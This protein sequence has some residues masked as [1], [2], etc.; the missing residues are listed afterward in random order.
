VLAD[1]F[2]GDDKVILFKTAVG[3]AEGTS[4]INVAESDDSSSLLNIGELQVSLF[5]N[6]G[7]KS[8]ET[9][10]VS[11]LDNL[12]TSEFSGNSLMKIDVQGYELEV[13]KGSGALLSRVNWVYVECSFLELYEGQAMFEE[14]D[15]VL[16][17][18]GFSMIQQFNTRYTKNGEAVQ[19]DCLYGRK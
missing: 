4:K 13:L 18:Q 6:T 11:R 14:V 2:S 12:L 8:T 15:E 3:S 1:V 10:K 5:P 9:V 19:A 17:N 16:V 7:R